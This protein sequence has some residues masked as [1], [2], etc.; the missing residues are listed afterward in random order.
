MND[1]DK[2]KPY[3]EKVEAILKTF[4]K[5]CQ[6]N[7]YDNKKT[8][9]IKYSDQIDAHLK[10]NYN[11]EENVMTI[12]DIKAT[13]HELFHMAFTNKKKLNRELYAKSDMYH[14]NGL[15]F[16][17]GNFIM[18]KGITEGFAEYLS[19]KCTD[20]KSK[21]FDYYFANLLI[22]IY[23]EEIIHFALKNDPMGF[24]N[25]EFFYDSFEYTMNLD[26]LDES[27]TNILF[28]AASKNIIDKTFDI[29]EEDDKKEWAEFIKSTKD[30]FHMSII[31][32]FKCIINEY[33]NCLEP[34]ISQQELVHLL[35]SFLTEE[36]YQIAFK[37]DK[38]NTLEQELRKIIT[39][40]SISK[41]TKN[42]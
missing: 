9:K 32:L 29:G 23:G 15:A 33:K 1:F 35:N 24:Y 40:F 11:P 28:I 20:N 14:E 8:L 21:D 5:D 19:R 10:G 13:P 17:Y 27:I 25:Y 6:K 26:Y 39:D 42:K 4:P 3:F 37:L 34:K 18:Y 2:F 12:Y 36:C 7:Y 22:S 16:K 31:N 41:I 30:I 38:E